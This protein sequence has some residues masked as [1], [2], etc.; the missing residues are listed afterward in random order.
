MSNER[1]ASPSQQALA[2][3]GRVIEWKQTAPRQRTAKGVCIGVRRVPGVTIRTDDGEYPA[4]EF[5]IEKPTGRKT[6]TTSFAD[7]NAT[8]LVAS[9][10]R[11]R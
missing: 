10:D 3:V 4:I 11:D 8:T 7:L 6:W 5:C 2:L 1:A 9:D